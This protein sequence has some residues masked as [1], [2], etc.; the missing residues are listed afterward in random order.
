[1]TG[2]RIKG[3]AYLADYPA[4]K[5]I[6]ACETCGWRVQ[7]D[8]QAMLDA[9]GDRALTL[10]IKD[11]AARQGCRFPEINPMRAQ[12]HCRARYENIASAYRRDTGR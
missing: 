9:G 11:I 12:E 7:Y 5:V 3:A 1:M 4:Q 10:L 6:A 8:K 2:E